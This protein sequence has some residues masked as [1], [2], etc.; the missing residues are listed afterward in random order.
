MNYGLCIAEEEMELS[1]FQGGFVGPWISCGYRPS[2]QLRPSKKSKL[3]SQENRLELL[4][5]CSFLIRVGGRHAI[6]KAKLPCK[7][8]LYIPLVLEG[9]KNIYRYSII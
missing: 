2:A 8:L 7:V 6:G 5:N 9:H 4:K 1:E 3:D